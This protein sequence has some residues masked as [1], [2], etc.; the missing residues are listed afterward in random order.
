MNNKSVIVTKLGGLEN[1]QII[2]TQAP[3]PEAG[4]VRIK[5]KAAGVSQADV[6]IREGMYPKKFKP[7]FT[8]G[9]DLIGVVDKLGSGVDQFQVGDT[10]AAITVIGSYTQYICWRA[11]DLTLI[12]S[13][14]DPIKAVCCLL[15]YMTAYQMLHRTAQVKTGERILIHSAAGGVGSALIQLG[16]IAGLEMLGTTSTSK[17]DVVESLGGT[18]IDYTQEDF[19]DR[20][21]QL[22]GDGVDAVFDAIGGDHF[23]RSFKTLR[24]GGRFVGYGFTS[25]M[26]KPIIGRIDTFARLVL[27]MLFPQ[28][29][30]AS[31]YG[32]MFVKAAHPDWFKQDLAK[33][34]NLL[35]QDKIDPLVSAV[36]P[37][38]EAPKA[39]E[40]IEKRQVR[41]KIVLSLS[42]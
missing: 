4:E 29:K 27:M 9:Y 35:R 38:E 25:K 6:T 36:L 14:I 3:E 15:N 19:V 39:L 22:T 20:I 18:P 21:S 5:V 12:P 42:K 37:L 31:F 16:K 11:D 10:V 8:L 40:M 33:L 41:G 32:I 7:P 24:R 34:F 1:L 17:L 26:G 28:G 30:K 2:E 23:T 13:D